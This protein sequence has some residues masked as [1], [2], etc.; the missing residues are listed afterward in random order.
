MAVDISAE[1]TRTWPSTEAK[2]G[3]DADIDYATQKSKAI[4]RAKR[5]L[6]GTGS[7]P[8]SESD[9]PELAAYWIADQ[10]VVFL[11][12]LA[13]SWYVHNRKLSDAKEGA[14]TS[15]YDAVSM[16]KQLKGELEASLARAKDDALSA[17]SS[18]QVE[19]DVPAVSH[20][21]MIVDPVERAVYRGPL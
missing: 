7:V 1:V 15:Y 12:P 4:A 14:T 13:E 18:A 5:A 2:L 19:D 6:Y 9:I 21:G 16:L 3:D 17:I 20:K 11:I 8:S 10:A